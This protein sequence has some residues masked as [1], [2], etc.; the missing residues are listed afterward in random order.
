MNFVNS[1]V[2]GSFPI[3][4]MSGGERLRGYENQ[5]DPEWQGKPP[6]RP[7]RG[8]IEAHGTASDKE[9]WGARSASS[10]ADAFYARV[11]LTRYGKST[12]SIEFYLDTV[13]LH[14]KENEQWKVMT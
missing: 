2:P 8:F 9:P 1:C 3:P 5:S 12:S 14:T 11:A 10:R 7:A 6:L 4:N 13:P